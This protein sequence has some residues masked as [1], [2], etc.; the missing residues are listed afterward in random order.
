MIYYSWVK[1]DSK[2]ILLGTGQDKSLAIGSSPATA[3]DWFMLTEQNKRESVKELLPELRGT[4]FDIHITYCEPIIEIGG[5]AIQL[6][7]QEVIKY[8]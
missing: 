4:S 2:G 6:I 7:D 1:R 8:E 5:H 3:E